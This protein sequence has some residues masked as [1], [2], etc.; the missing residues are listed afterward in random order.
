MDLPTWVVVLSSLGLDSFAAQVEFSR[1][2]NKIFSVLQSGEN[3]NLFRRF[4][5]RDVTQSGDLVLVEHVNSLQ[6]AALDQC[7]YVESAAP[8]ARRAGSAPSRRAPSG[9]RISGQFDFH[10]EAAAGRVG[11]RNDLHDLAGESAFPSASIVTGLICPTW[12]KR[13]SLSSTVTSS[14]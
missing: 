8:T 3:F 1:L 10:Q 9:A 2:G 6:L 14:R 7:A 12:T 11:G 4:A 5:Q 13:R